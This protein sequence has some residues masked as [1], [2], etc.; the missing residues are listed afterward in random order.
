M[1]AASRITSATRRCLVAICHNSPIVFAKTA[2][3]LMELGWG[4]R[5]EEAKKAHGFDA[6]HFC[7]EASLP[8]V[9]ALR[10]VVVQRALHH[11]AGYTHIL[12]LDADMV[13]PTDVLLQ[14][15]RYHDKG[16]V[17]GRYHLKGGT[18]APVAMMNGHVPEGSNTKQ[19]AFDVDYRNDGKTDADGLRKVEIVGMG[20]TLIPMEVFRTLERPWF[21]YENDDD[22]WPRVSEDVPFCRNAGEA[23][24]PIYWAPAVDCGHATINVVTEGYFISATE[25]AVQGLFEATQRSANAKA[26]AA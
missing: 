26:S 14:M 9:D 15:L 2:Q 4:N 21:Y 6:I 20:C 12:F 8:R 22:G 5:V 1:K 16:I 19:Y 18:F 7:W 13:W 11:S 23:G 25:G 3:S 24:F 17:S 10:N